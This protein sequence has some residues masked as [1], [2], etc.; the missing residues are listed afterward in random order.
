MIAHR[1]PR[2]ALAGIG[3]HVEE[4][5]GTWLHLPLPHGAFRWTA[6]VLLAMALLVSW[7]PHVR[8]ASASSLNFTQERPR[9][10]FR[11]EEGRE[12]SG[13]ALFAGAPLAPGNMVE[14]TVT[15][16]NTGK[17]AAELRVLATPGAGTPGPLWT[18]DSGLQATVSAA[19]GDTLF[20]GPARRL[21]EGL[22]KALPAGADTT[23]RIAIGLPADAGAEVQGQRQAV[24]FFFRIDQ[25]R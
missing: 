14:R 8:A 23:L 22:P 24:D 2:L 17:A 13:S 18:S 20:S 3:S 15:A 21:A 1:T 7:A 9:V 10:T 6:T 4:S 16:R 19:N 11:D 25:A 12:I 5:H